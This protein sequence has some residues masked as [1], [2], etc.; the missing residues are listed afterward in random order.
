MESINT[1]TSKK[2]KKH[3][4]VI[5]FHGIGAPDR[6]SSLTQFLDY[7]D[8]YGQSKSKSEIG[9]P[10]DFSYSTEIISDDQDDIIGYVE[11]KRILEHKGNPF[12]SRSIRFYEGYWTPEANTKFNLAYLLLWLLSRISRPFS[13]HFS[14]WRAYAPIRIN[15]LHK[16]VGSGQHSITQRLER[17]YRDFENWGN[18]GN[19]PRGTEGEFIAFIRAST[20]QEPDKVVDLARQWMSA[21]RV[22][23][24]LVCA[25]SAVLAACFVVLSWS[26]IWLVIAAFSFWSSEPASVPEI[27]AWLAVATLA[28]LFV[29]QVR[30]VFRTHIADILAWT[31]SSE[32]DSGFD[33]RAR[34][35]KFAQR[36]I[37]HVTSNDDCDRC[38]VIGH[39]LGSCIALEAL[40]QEGRNAK[41]KAESGTNL[42]KIPFVFT[43]GSPIDLIFDFFQADRSYSHR[44]N[45]LEEEKR[46]SISLPPFLV[47]ETPTESRIVNIWSR[48]DPLAY[49]LFSARK[50]ISEPRETVINVEVLSAGSPFGN[51]TGYFQDQNV[52][53]L[54]YWAVMTGRMPKENTENFKPKL[55]PR[56]LLLIISMTVSLCLLLV[57]S[58]F[59]FTGSWVWLAMLAAAVT[60]VGFA[61]SLWM[62]KVHKSYQ[63]TGGDFL[64]R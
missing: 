18:R 25:L 22:Q 34:V 40:L 13:V 63:S 52:M 51:H 24:A 47:D 44:H 45:R 23:T 37:R 5:Y 4:A 2:K 14:K 31:I 41:L 61:V 7:F 60:A 27:S 42:R 15:V 54:I 8:L 39:S 1:E 29:I 36:L 20:V 57:L 10:R 38:I 32:R 9:K 28:L 6:E 35:I 16:L 17:L 43:I 3:T 19:Y 53:H 48:F 56:W 55:P 11:F 50:R 30:S 49:P 26:I 59:L 64:R 46:L 12:V 58:L 33:A 62:T 21:F